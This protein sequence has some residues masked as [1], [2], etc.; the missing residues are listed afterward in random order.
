M[1]ITKKIF[2][3]RVAVLLLCGFVLLASCTKNFKDINTDKN[4][5]TTI[6]PGEL[7]FLFSRAQSVAT[8]NQ[9]NYQVAQ[10]L[11]ADQYAQYFACEATYFGSDRLSIVQ[12]WVSAAFNP[13]Y[14][15][16]VPQL[17]TLFKNYP[18]TTAE[19]AIA[20]IVWVLAFHKVTDY[21]GPIPY[22]KVGVPTTAVPYDAQDKIYDDFFKKLDSS[23]TTLKGLP[24]NTKA[25]GG[26]YDLIYG[27]KIDLW[28][29][30]ASTL[31]LR[32][33][34]R[35][36]KVDA[37]RAR[38]EAESAV[39]SGVM[40]ASP[41]DDA[42][43]KRTTAGGD[44][45]G[46]SIMSDWNE[47]R[48]SASMASVLKGYQDPRL[49]VYFLPTYDVSNG[50]NYYQ[51]LR[52]GLTV[53]Q[54]GK[55]QNDHDMN[56]HVGQRWS[57]TNVVDKNKVPLGIQTSLSTPQNVMCTAEAY[58]LRAEGALLG[59]N[60]GGTAKDLYNAGITNSLAQW[61]ITDNTAVQNYI[62]SIKTPI[63]P[64][65]YLNSP[66]MTTIPVLFGA[67]PAVQLEQIAT[68]KWLALFP[69]GEEAWAD[70]RRSHVLKLY[71]VA[72]SDNPDLPDPTTQWIR[73]INYLTSEIQNNG[74]EV[75]KAIQ[76]L[77]GPDKI[78]TP[79]WWDKN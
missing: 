56:S 59:W 5:V 21:W 73:R 70:Y 9:A 48:M 78:T 60:M 18:S 32:L 34:L 29:K 24:A 27:G 46:L 62:N 13:V 79:L 10:N 15:D 58:F 71:P 14:T 57:S 26:S 63:A 51:G 7:P 43:I 38:T 16:V 41:G 2:D 76:L 25:Y 55:P 67:T 20:N 17:Q 44:G 39:A 61:G 47:F 72:N 22:F 37:T 66:P 31:R 65:D 53:D 11:F 4:K 40:M 6:G 8:I 3:R 12:G 74:D 30:F 36:S 69:D 50:T 28:I 77:G 49:P 45:N 23:I 33:A 68:Q 42:L 52:N 75:K 54:L 19:Y 64:G 35:I 1:K